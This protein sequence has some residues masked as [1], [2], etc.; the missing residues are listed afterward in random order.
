MPELAFQA[1]ADVPWRKISAS[2]MQGLIGGGI[3]IAQKEA[4]ILGASCADVREGMLELAFRAC[5]GA[6]CT[7]KTGELAQGLVGGGIYRLDCETV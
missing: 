3:N 2:T 6:A 7:Q 4:R 1:Q 5:G